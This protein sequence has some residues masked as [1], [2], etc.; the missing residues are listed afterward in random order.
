MVADAKDMLDVKHNIH[1]YCLIY[2]CFIC[3]IFIIITGM[4][5]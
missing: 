1:T 2:T 5:V 3:F 4:T